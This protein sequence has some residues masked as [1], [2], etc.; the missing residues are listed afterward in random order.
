MSSSRKIHLFDGSLGHSAGHF[1]NQNRSI[2]EYLTKEN[3][4]GHVFGHRSPY[5]H[6]H[7]PEKC[8]DIFSISLIQIPEILDK[9][10]GS[11]SEISS[12]TY[13]DLKDLDK[14]LFQPDDIILYHSC[15][16]YFLDGLLKWLNEFE[17]PPFFACHC[18]SDFY[19]PQNIQEIIHPESYQIFKNIFD[20]FPERLKNKVYFFNERNSAI[21]VFKQV[22]GYK[23]SFQIDSPCYVPQIL[24]S[25]KIEDSTAIHIGFLAKDKARGA[26]LVSE[27]M[28]HFNGL[29]HFVFHWPRYIK[30]PQEYYTLLQKMDLVV[31][32]YDRTIYAYQNSGVFAECMGLGITTIIPSQTTI[33]QEND[34][35][36]LNQI[37]YDSDDPAEISR[38]IFYFYKSRIAYKKQANEIKEKFLKIRGTPSYIQKIVQIS[39]YL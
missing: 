15:H 3:M 24:N 14:S 22:L 29:S 23:N 9:N 36:Q 11:A 19:N 31:L 21:D 12:I 4:A 16:V 7:V 25:E 26:H 1:E 5:T 20:N 33:A 17:S 30:D 18:Y 13:D 32:P 2:I 6:I 34:E 38:K 37:L 27:I 35:L 28:G 10:N 8:H 39:S